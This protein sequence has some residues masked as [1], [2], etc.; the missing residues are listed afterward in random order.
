MEL[1]KLEKNPIG[2]LLKNF[3]TNLEP[4]GVLPFGNNC[5]KSKP[6]SG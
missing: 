5:N 1:E 6:D 2:Q 3:S 4:K